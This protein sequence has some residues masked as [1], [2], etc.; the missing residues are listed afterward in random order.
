M[1]CVAKGVERLLS[2]HKN[3]NLI[4]SIQTQGL[5]NMLVFPALRK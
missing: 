2:M 5:W 4:P 1:G 3:L